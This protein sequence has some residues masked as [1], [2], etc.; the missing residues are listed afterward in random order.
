MAARSESAEEAGAAVAI[1]RLTMTDALRL[2]EQRNR[3]LREAR[4]TTESAAADVT[5][6]RQLPNPT[7][8]L[9]TTSIN[10][11][12]TRA[13][14]GFWD[15]PYDTVV[16][17]D[18]PIERGD[19][20]RYR[21]HAAK[22][23]LAAARADQ[24]VT[25]RQMRTQTQAAYY[26]LLRAQEQERINHE[27]AALYDKSIDAAELR[28][29]AGDIALTD[30]TRLRIEALKARNDARQAQAEREK[31]QY[32][33]AYLLGVETRATQLHAIDSWPALRPV[34]AP[35]TLDEVLVHRADID[36]AEARRQAAQENRELARALRTRDITIGVQYEHEPP[37]GAN[38][39]GVGFSVPLFTSYRYQGEI[40]RAESGLLASEEAVQRARAQ[41]QT[42][43]ASLWADLQAAGERR[44][45]YDQEL[46]PKSRQATDAEEFAYQHGARSVLDLIDVRRT[47]HAVQLEAVAANADYA[48]ALSA[49]TNAVNPPDATP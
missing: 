15:Q 21:A 44:Q 9:N 35:A 10:P 12:L 8:S 2:F 32:M 24:R 42:D 48:K 38:M 47:L 3:E 46:L 6:A 22:A 36:A 7:L 11:S 41:A 25:A 30:V 34:T 19:K 13:D 40:Q 39:Y 1:E 27:T 31:A 5:A 43:I 18:Q 45:R 20:R 29:K 28:L 33:L 23:L 26:D 17:I 4:R 14:G 37:G 49:W 16:R